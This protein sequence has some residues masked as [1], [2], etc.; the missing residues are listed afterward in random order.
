MVSKCLSRDGHPRSYRSAAESVSIQGPTI[1]ILS[2]GSGRV[3]LTQVSGHDGNW[4]PQS[5]SRG[6]GGQRMD[7]EWRSWAEAWARREGAEIDWAPCGG[8]MELCLGLALPVWPPTITIL[9]VSVSYLN[10]MP[11]TASGKMTRW[12]TT[13]SGA[14]T[15]GKV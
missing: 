3:C 9:W 15:F 1:H 6:V 5:I 11:G 14:Y 8:K 4:R 2:K 7:T 13:Q 10:E 12:I